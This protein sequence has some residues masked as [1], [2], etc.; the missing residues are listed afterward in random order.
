ME[1][2]REQHV[3]HLSETHNLSNQSQAV[4]NL[5]LKLQSSATKAQAKT[6]DLE[7]KKL[8]AQQA[9]TLR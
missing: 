4:M 8:E 3:T 1:S 2:L 6:I 5:N 7:L 9:S